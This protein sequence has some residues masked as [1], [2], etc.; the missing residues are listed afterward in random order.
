MKI[1]LSLYPGGVH[2][3]L[4]MS[5]DDGT[6]HDRRLVE[7]FHTYGIRG[8]FHLNSRRL[9]EPGYI[10]ANEVARLYRGQEV[11]SHTASHPFCTRLS[12]LDVME[13]VLQDRAAL[14]ARCGYPVCGISYPYGDY[15]ERV[16]RLFRTCGIEYART[17]KSTADFSFPPHPMIWNPTAHHNENI[18]ERLEAFYTNDRWSAGRLLYIWGHSYEFEREQNWCLME[19][20]CKRAGGRDDTW[21]ATNREIIDYMNAQHALRI[22]ADRKIVQNPSAVDVWIQ[23]D[24]AA[25]TIPAGQTIFIG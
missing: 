20:F 2:H 9:D 12:S 5:Y 23:A 25:V 24:G 22:S 4:T 18:L 8:T 10:T 14:E 1:E 17:T 6:C 19:E 16:I 21:Y 13:E 11:A 3:V 15:D 7:L